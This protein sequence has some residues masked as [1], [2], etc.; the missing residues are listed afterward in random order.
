MVLVNDAADESEHRWKYVDDLTL[1]EV[2]K[3]NQPTTLQNSLDNISYWC[4]QNDVLPKPSKCNLLCINFLR[5]M[6]PRTD[7]TLNEIPLNVVSHFKLLGVTIQ[8]DL[9]WNLHVQE[10]VSKASR[11]LYTLCILNRRSKTPI[12]D[13]V[14]VYTCYIRPILEYACPV[15]HTSITD[16]QTNA[17]EFVQKR[18]LRIILGRDYTSY[19]VALS[20][21]KLPSLSLRRNT[22]LIDFGTKMLQSLKH[23]HLLPPTK[24]STC[25]RQLRNMSGLCTIKCNTERYRKSTI[26]YLARTLKP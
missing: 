9:K 19:S 8:N 4:Q 11:R 2:I 18:A 17:I 23:R 22:L 21:C 13:M 5:Q 24:A 3:R 25:T 1:G 26:P 6:N 14:T 10:I 7:I 16:A 12:T 20:I 15:W